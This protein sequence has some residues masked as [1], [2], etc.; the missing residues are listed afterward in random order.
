MSW[1]LDSCPRVDGSGLRIRRLGGGVGEWA[2]VGRALNLKNPKTLNREVFE[3]GSW[4]ARFENPNTKHDSSISFAL[5]AECYLSPSLQNIYPYLSATLYI[6]SLSRSVAPT[7][8][9]RLYTYRKHADVHVYMVYMYIHIIICR[10]VYAHV[11]IIA[12]LSSEPT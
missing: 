1:V 12:A 4:A 8:I 5:R 10:H 3:A 6:N 9:I 11:H 2:L 7:L